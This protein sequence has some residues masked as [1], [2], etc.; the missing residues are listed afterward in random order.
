RQVFEFGFFHGDPHPG[1]LLI[2]DDGRLVVLDFGVVGTLTGAMQD[3]LL[4]AFTSLVFRDAETL[5]RTLYRAGAVRGGRVDLREL[6]H[7]I[8]RKM[9]QYHGASL[10]EMVNPATLMDLVQLCTRFRI[11][12]PP[13]M[14]VLSRAATLI[15]AQ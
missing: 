11:T 8:E 4:D 6:T 15:E 3:T 5:A 9:L 14:A 13:E 10:D 12:L 2:T 1:N 7:E